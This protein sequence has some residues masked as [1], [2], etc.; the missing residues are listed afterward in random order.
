MSFLK[1]ILLYFSFSFGFLSL[2]GIENWIPQVVSKLPHQL[3]AFTEGL[4]I[5]DDQLYESTGN[6]KRSALRKIDLVTGKVIQKKSIDP[7]FFAEGIAVFPD[8]IIQLTWKENTAFLYDRE[9]LKLRKT[10]SYSGEG[11]GLCRDGETVWMS[12]G[13]A[14]IVQRDGQT[15]EPLRAIQV[16]QGTKLIEGINDL[17]CVDNDLFAN[18]FKSDFIIK[19]NKKTGEIIG[20][21]DC[22]DLLSE[23]EKKTLRLSNVLNGITYR[24][25]TG[26][27]FVTGKEWPWIFEIKLIR[28]KP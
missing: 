28:V 26:T 27:F 22:S 21:I 25:S 14:Q 11:W 9:T 24:S 23:Q 18:I 15:F 10:F 19:V 1:K 7:T 17:T 4:A 12:N 20:M 5:V 13:T 3:P 16:H 6:Y 8:Q 2:E